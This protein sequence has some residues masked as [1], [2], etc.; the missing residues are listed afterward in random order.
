MKNKDIP[1]RALENVVPAPFY[2]NY[3]RTAHSPGKSFV[4]HNI[5][6]YSEIESL[7]C[8]YSTRLCSPSGAPNPYPDVCSFN[9]E[10]DNQ[11]VNSLDF[12]WL[13]L[14]PKCNLQCIHC[15]ADSGLYVPSKQ[16]MCYEDW[17]SILENAFG[18]GCKKVQFIGGEPTLYPYL[19]NLIAD[20]RNIGYEFIEVFTNGTLLNS[21]LMETF[22]KFRVNLAFSVYASNADIHDAITLQKGSFL[23][24]ISGIR[25]AIDYGLSI[26]VGIIVMQLNSNDIKKAVTYLKNLG[27]LSVGI[28]WVRG[29]G[30]GNTLSQSKSPLDNFC[31][32]C[33]QNKLCIDSSG[34][35]F[36]C[37]FARFC[38]VGHVSEGLK[39][40]LEGKLL[41]DFRRSMY[42]EI[43]S[44][45]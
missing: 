13:E 6:P 23:K 34:Q 40:I 18:L 36:P 20:A 17:R 5:E 43:I 10:V 39:K 14:T 15:Y 33:C 26:R 11:W 31:S 25:Q 8:N 27:V 16:M 22:Q 29:I 12:L 7:N 44:Q 45:T 38:Q 1:L 37:I 3:Q 19:S 4:N 42:D 24:T 41:Q 28:D 30:R 32:A 21:L 2:S 9:K 35:V